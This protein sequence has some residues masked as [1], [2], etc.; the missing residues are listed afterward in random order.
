MYV[1]HGQYFCS[2]LY[3]CF[4][5]LSTHI[6]SLQAKNIVF[7]FITDIQPKGFS[8][9]LNIDWNIPVLQ[10]PFSPATFNNFFAQLFKIKH[11]PPAVEVINAENNPQYSGH[12]LLVEDNHVNQLVA[13]QILKN[14]G[15]TCD[16][17]ENGQ[18][19][20]DMVSKNDA[21]DLVLMDIQMPIMDGYEAT[22]LIRK[23]WLYRFNHLRTFCKRHEKR[24]GAR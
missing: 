14:F 23:K 18:Q 8:K 21:Y 15:L 6:E 17:A 9:Q 1:I 7:A 13:G 19:A 4:F 16:I 5:H 3:I 11:V 22:R 24:S 12:I 20:V 10:H 2:K